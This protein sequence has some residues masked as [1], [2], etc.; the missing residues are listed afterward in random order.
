MQQNRPVDPVVAEL[1]PSG[2]RPGSLFFDPDHH[3]VEK[4]LLVRVR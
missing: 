1:S 3:H 2:E 4:R